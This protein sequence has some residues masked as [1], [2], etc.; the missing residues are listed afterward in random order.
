MKIW[1]SGFSIDIIILFCHGEKLFFFFCC[2]KKSLKTVRVASTTHLRM[3]IV[4][5]S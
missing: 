3:L 2:I 1:A 4:A 5:D